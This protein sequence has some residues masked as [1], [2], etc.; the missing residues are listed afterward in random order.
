MK[1]LCGGPLTVYDDRGVAKL[2]CSV[3]VSGV[4]ALQIGTVDDLGTPVLLVVTVLSPDALAEV[5]RVGTGT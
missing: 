2:I 5:A 3:L 4:R 1:G